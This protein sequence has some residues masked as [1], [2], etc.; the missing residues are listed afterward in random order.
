MD[1][2]ITGKT[3]LVFASTRG[4]G[5]GVAKALSMD[6]ANVVISGRDENQL[7]NAIQSIEKESHSS[8]FGF[9]CDVTDL[10]QQDRLFEYC[11]E[12][13]GMPDILVYNAGG[14]K[15]GDPESFSAHDFQEA[16]SRGFDPAVHAIKTVL[17]HMKKMKWGRILAITSVSVKQPLDDLLLSNTTRS[18]L[19]SYIKTISRQVGNDGITVN[20]ILPGPHD[21]DRLASL[22]E[23]IAAQHDISPA[24]ALKRLS[25]DI[26]VGRPGTIDEF[27]A[28][29]A[30]LCSKH[31]SYITGQAIVHD[32]GGVRA[33]F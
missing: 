28:V 25:S 30:F 16:F 8:V 26:P 5:Y 2:G 12:K 17:P 6:H 23:S 4:L 9:S 15:A 21:T 11:I 7:H 10:S 14:P 20:S 19:T 24:D 32:G 1:L 18:A 13:A 33:V 29:A 31:A 27:G 3:A 22:A